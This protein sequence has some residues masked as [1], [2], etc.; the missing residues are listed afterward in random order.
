M[1]L[2]SAWNTGGGCASSAEVVQEYGK[3]VSKIGKKKCVV[4]GEGLFSG[5]VGGRNWGG[6]RTHVVSVH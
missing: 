2:G 6:R 4:G 1:G 5:G 3:R